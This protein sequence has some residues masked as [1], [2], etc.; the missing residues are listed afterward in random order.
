M[1]APGTVMVAVGGTATLVATTL[2]SSGTTLAGR[3]VSWSSANSSVASVSASGIVT[4]TGAGQTTVTATSE[5]KQGTASVT[6]TN[7]GAAFDYNIAGARFTQGVQASDGSIPIVLSGNSA[8]VNIL[9][10]SASSTQVVPVELRLYDASGT[11]YATLT[12]TAVPSPAPTYTSPSAQILVSPANIRAGMR[13]EVVRDPGAAPD[14]DP[15]NDRFP[16]SG[17][18]AQATVATPS[19]RIRF[20]PITLSSHG[21]QT[22]LVNASNLAEYQRT[23]LSILPLSTVD[24]TIGTPFATSASFGSPP[25][26]GDSPFWIQVM[27][28]LDVARM[29]S[30]VD[31]DAH[32]YG[33]VRPPTGFNFTQFGGFAFIPT[34]AQDVGPSTRT[35]VSTQV[36]WFSTPSQGR[37]LVAH[38]M[39]HNFGRRHAPCGGA[40]SP[41]GAYPV[42]GGRLDEPGHDVRGWATGRASSATTISTTTGDAMGYCFPVWASNYTYRAILT[43]RGTIG[44]GL[45]AEQPAR[46]R[47]IVIRGREDAAGTITLDPAFAI[48]ARP[49]SDNPAGD[50][51][52]EGRAADGRVLFSQRFATA[53]LDHAPGVRLFTLTIPLSETA[54]SSLDA[55]VVTGPRGTARIARGAASLT[56]C[57]AGSSAVTAMQDASTGELL[58][59]LTGASAMASMPRGR[60]LAL[61]CSDG[62]R[63]LSTIRTIQ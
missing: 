12:A 11:R 17:T 26:G 41:D 13:W 28:E 8:A 39:G 61:A 56:A 25:S 49:T 44:A 43:F 50:H 29:A 52:L 58:G 45:M 59:I 23:L 4:G 57:P 19:T 33:I 47:V 46:R 32:W 20:I 30:S 16:R 63:T 35:A 31:T 36:D 7:S 40:G 24:A 18:A 48:T 60:R 42:A 5:G 1:V 14:S 37:D 54:E 62:L 27:Q 51:R 10:S 53:E 2:S 9:V 34:N 3:A 22:S 38:E 6:V 15:A 21:S 55:I